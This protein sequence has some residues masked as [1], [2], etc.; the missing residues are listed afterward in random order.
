MSNIGSYENTYREFTWNVPEYFNFAFD[1]IDNWAKDPN[2]LAMLWVDEDGQKKTF[3][4]QYFQ[5]RS[6]QVANALESLGLKKGDRVLLLMSR[7]PA[8]W[9]LVLGMIKLGVVFL[10]ATTQLTS[11]DIAYRVE[12][13]QACAVITDSENATKFDAIREKLPNINIFLVVGES[14]ENWYC[15]NDLIEK[16]STEF[17]AKEKTHKDD[18]LLL[19]FTSGTTGYPKMVLHTHSSYP[20]GHQ[21]TGRY[22]LDLQENDLH[23][24]LSDT[25]WAKA[26]W[27]SLFGPW[28]TGSTLFVHNGKGKFAPELTLELLS[29]HKITSF[30]APPTAYRMLVGLDLQ[31]YNLENLRSCVSAGEPL[32]PEIID[33]WEEK[34]KM[35]I[36]EGYGQTETCLLVGTFPEMIV[37]K[38]SMGKSAPGFIVDI[39]DEQGSIANHHQEGDIGVR[40]SPTRPVG[41]FQEYWQDTQATK[42]SIRGDWYITGDR[43]F[44]DQDGYL[45]F[46][47]RADDV[48]ISAGYRIG[49][50]EVESALIEHPQVLE[51]AVVGKADNARGQIVKAYVILKPGVEK[52]LELV[53]TLQEFVK[54]TT[55]PYKYPREI[56]FVDELPKTISGKI[57]R[58]EL[59][60][61]ANKH[62]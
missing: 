24:N 39:I 59:R 52:T 60:E 19:Y 45:W 12:V 9:E 5:R 23:W 53:T 58:I 40:I 54:Q 61:R 48:I 3:T 57:R 32:N 11:K 7:L 33:I 15:Y 10:P 4:Y 42:N 14:Q 29:E 13:S 37:K 47:G 46:I 26:A 21:I 55:A 28:N 35:L 6:N 50:F 41:I 43:G 1:V 20:I 62:F 31:N 2:K 8:W 30:C 36:R 49:P 16:T 44:R 51:A 56:E 18:P 27:S 17:N 38:G 22:W 34:T 25:G